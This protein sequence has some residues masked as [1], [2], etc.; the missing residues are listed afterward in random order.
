MFAL[1]FFHVFL[2][3]FPYNTPGQMQ[4]T[5][6]YHTLA[7]THLTDFKLISSKLVKEFPTTCGE[8]NFITVFKKAQHVFEYRGKEFQFLCDLFFINSSY[9]CLGLASCLFPS[10]YPIKTV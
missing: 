7:L 2:F 9:L 10:A 3:Y 8:R 5:L 6:T 4:L 1:L